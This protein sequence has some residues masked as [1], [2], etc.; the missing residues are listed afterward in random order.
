MEGIIYERRKNWDK[1]RPETRQGLC[2]EKTLVISRLNEFYEKA[3]HLLSPEERLVYGNLRIAMMDELAKLARKYKIEEV[4]L[5]YKPLAPSKEYLTAQ[6]HRLLGSTV[7]ESQYLEEPHK[8]FGII[9]GTLSLAKARKLRVIRRH[10]G[11]SFVVS[12]V[13]ELQGK[14]E[15]DP[16]LIANLAFTIEDLDMHGN[17]VRDPRPIDL[18]ILDAEISRLGSSF[19]EEDMRRATERAVI[20]AAKRDVN[21]QAPNNGYFPFR[22]AA[23]K[24]V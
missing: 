16:R 20:K 22:R 23:L 19:G 17:T 13:Y 3:Y 6:E 10:S 7:N 1:L 12:G 11:T 2:Q 5:F 9:D 14:I 24:F 15:A 4:S 21:L 18:R 8:P